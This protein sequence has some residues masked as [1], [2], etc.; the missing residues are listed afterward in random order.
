[1][2]KIYTSMI[3]LSLGAFCGLTLSAQ[4][5]LNITFADNQLPAKW[6][7]YNGG[8]YSFENGHLNVVMAVQSNGK[9]RADLWYNR[10][11]DENYKITD[12]SNIKVMA[13]KFIGQ[14]PTGSLKLEYLGDFTNKTN[15][16]YKGEIKTSG[17][18]TIYY[19]DLNDISDYTTTSTLNR[20]HFTIADCEVEPFEYSVDWIATFES[21]EALT[22]NKDWKDD[23]EN[24]I[25]EEGEVE[26]TFINESTNQG[27]LSFDEMYDASAV[28][29]TLILKDDVVFTDRKPTKNVTIKGETGNEK[30]IQN[31]NNKLL[32]ACG[33]RFALENLI[34]TAQNGPGSTPMFEVAK[35]N[36]LIL[37]DVTFDGIKSSHSEGIINIKT[38][39][40][41]NL[42]N[43]NFVNCEGSTLNALCKVG[44]TKT[45]NLTGKN[46]GLKVY[47]EAAGCINASELTNEQPIVLTLS[48]I[49]T[50]SPAARSLSENDVIVNGCDDPSKFDLTNSGYKLVG[51]NGNLVLAKAGDTT[52][53]D[54]I[55][56]DGEDAPVEYYNVQGIRVEN[57]EHGLYIKRQ[58]NK[59]SKVIL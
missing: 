45:L 57:P 47:V 15:W 51:E 34:V 28:G 53:I 6:E 8:T 2:K 46:E 42:T 25:D 19:W 30:L 14:R 39:G 49:L 9:Y 31:F 40:A 23:G 4:E 52:A 22:E 17:G 38:D 44:A 29:H 16:T 59:V 33:S 12:V 18:N 20:Y 11:T 32:F 13:I 21:I 24:D 36:P 3:A 48:E 26:Y 10:T 55:G 41:L 5:Q 1:M 54:E 50:E 37:T 43:V 35:N 56:V 58:G 27:Y 7:V